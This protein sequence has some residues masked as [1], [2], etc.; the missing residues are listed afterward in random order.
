MFYYK[1]SF[2][3]ISLAPLGEELFKKHLSMKRFLLS[4][5][6]LLV[7]VALTACSQKAKWNHEQKK[8]MREN[9]RQYRDMIYLQDLTD[10]EFMIFTD[11][12][13]GDIE[14]VYPVYT[15]FIEMDGAQDTVDMFVVGAIV[16]QLDA[17]AHNMRHI[18]PYRYLVAEGLLPDKLTHDQQHSFYTCLAQKV[19]SHFYSMEQFLLAI[20][21][22]TTASSQMAQF[23]QQ[24]A[25]ELF[26]WVIEID[27]VDIIP[28]APSK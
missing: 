20:L 16:E 12:V 14:A 7:A 17:D 24:C 21:A 15:S 27:E 13:T 26:D 3:G 9:L 2:F 11:S 19:N 5:S 1:D 8:A 18:Y 23:Q 6:V 28:V 4:L 22:D 10:P 25:N